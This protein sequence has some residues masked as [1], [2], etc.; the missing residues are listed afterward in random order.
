MK[1]L[2][3]SKILIIPNLKK[4]R[5]NILVR[6]FLIIKLFNFQYHL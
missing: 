5:T 2:K 6:F 1:N 4:K 3:K